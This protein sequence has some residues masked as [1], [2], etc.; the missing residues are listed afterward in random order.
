MVPI[1]AVSLTGVTPC[2]LILTLFSPHMLPNL[3]TLAIYQRHFYCSN[4]CTLL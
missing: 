2:H 4:W 1:T 3:K